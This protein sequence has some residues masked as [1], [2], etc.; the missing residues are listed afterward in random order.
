MLEV[1]A[2]LRFL[3]PLGRRGG[4]LPVDADPTDSAGHLVQAAG[5]PH[6]EVGALRLDGVPI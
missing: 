4:R 5:I 3:L 6:T 1:A 2:D